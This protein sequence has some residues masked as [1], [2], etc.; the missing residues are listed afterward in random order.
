MTWIIGGS[1]IFGYGVMLSDIQVTFSNGKTADLVQKAFL[2]SNFLSAGFA[3]SVKIGFMLLDS[4]AKLTYMSPEDCQTHAWDPLWIANE[5]QPLAK[6]I[7]D[8]APA[9]ERKLGSQ[10]LIVCASPT[11]NASLGSKIYFIN[12][13]WPEFK[14]EIMTDSVKLCSI[15][16]GAD[17]VEYKKA[18]QPLLDFKSGIL[19]A[20]VGNEGGWAQAFAFSVTRLLN[21]KP[22]NGISK[23]L[24]VHIIRRGSLY[25]FNNNE[26]IHRKDGLIVDFKMPNVARSY[27]EFVKMVSRMSSKAECAIC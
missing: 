8:A 1:T 15:G 10:F 11:E 2:I 20:E 23:H 7:F 12:L 26:R 18:L 27:P 6:K 3:G 25:E 21:D 16:S 9:E 17:V 19:Q 13:S 22:I 14:P 5:W 4:L 24:N